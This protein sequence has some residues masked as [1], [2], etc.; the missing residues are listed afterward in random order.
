MKN[1]A[2]PGRILKL[3]LGDMGISEAAARLKVSRPTLSKVING[4]AG[5]S[6]DMALRLEAFLGNPGEFWLDL[7]KQFELAQAKRQ[8]RPSIQP[9]KAA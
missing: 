4:R 7:Q 6:A 1:P 8:K 5:I 2:H 9:M 3:A